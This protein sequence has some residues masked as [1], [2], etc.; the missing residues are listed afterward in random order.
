VP[1]KDFATAAK[2]YGIPGV[3]VVGQVVFQVY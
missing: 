1:M 2:T 3:V